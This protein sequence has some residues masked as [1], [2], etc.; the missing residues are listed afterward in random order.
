MFRFSKTLLLLSLTL[1]CC[2][3]QKAVYLI[4]PFGDKIELT[5]P[6][7]LN[8]SSYNALIDTKALFNNTY[9]NADTSFVINLSGY[10]AKLKIPSSAFRSISARIRILDHVYIHDSTMVKENN[11]DIA[12]IKFSSGGSRTRLYSEYVAAVTDSLVCYIDFYTSKSDSILFWKIY[13]N[14]CKSLRI[15]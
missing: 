14:V 15:N 13:D 12:L 2:K 7:S 11:T 10:W 3:T 9:L 4:K 1:I 5:I 6:L 8:E